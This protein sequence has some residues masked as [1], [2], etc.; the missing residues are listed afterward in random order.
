MSRG[1]KKQLPEFYPIS[2]NAWRSWLTKNH[3]TSQSIW[4]ILC[5]KESGLPTLSI[6]EANEEALCFGW[7][8]SVPGKVDDK[9]FKLLMS[10]RNPKSKWSKVN[11]ERVK[12][13]IK[14]KLMTPAGMEVINQ[15]KKSGTWNALNEV[16]RMVIPEDLKRAFAKN[17]KARVY[18]EAF[19]P[20]TKRGILEWISSAKQ[21]ETRLRRI[22]ETVSL[23]MKNIRANQFRKPK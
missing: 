6:K 16:E 10:P 1:V 8:D 14:E 12:V 2:R 3:K 7:I 5:K 22:N 17:K 23:A 19:P 11:K 4:L 20:S 13:L 18:F 21:P 15:A 9:R